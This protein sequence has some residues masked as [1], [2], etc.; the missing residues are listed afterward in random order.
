MSEPSSALPPDD[1]GRF[2]LGASADGVLAVDASGV[3]RLCNRAAEDLFARPAPELLGSQFGYPIAVGA[4][5]I[6]VI[7]P[8]GEKR[9]VEMRVTATTWQGERLHVAALR[10]V[11]R[12]R[13]AEREL[14]AEIEEQHIVVGIAAHEL[15]SPLAAISVLAHVL[16]DNEATLTPQRRVEITDRII[17]R[18]TYL[19]A[20]VRKLLTASR[21]DAA[22]RRPVVERVRVLEVIIEQLADFEQ[23]SKD[24]RVSC[25][26]RL[27]AVVDRGELS[28]ML[29]NYLENAFS[30]GQPPIEIQAQAKA[31][32]VEV[33]VIDHG[34][35]VPD[36]F[37]ADLFERFTRGPGTEH[38]TD[39]T[40]LGL[41]IVRNLARAN[42]GDAW[43][44]PGKGGGAR[45][46][47]R[48]R[49][50]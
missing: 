33:R 48:L 14:Q 25:S 6:D 42:G 23:R 34:P 26:E 47:L 19:Q 15:H 20:L 28:E 49:R 4:S 41:W 32:W 10:D 40:G 7:L 8:G 22:G 12:R 5:E 1:V 11:T 13:D 46:C 50:T 35:G 30:Y 36:S 39:G 18:T 27:E 44:E 24:A 43:Y 21:I 9:T 3:I 37:V 29:A 45:F 38:Q 31:G 17:E 2:I 16:R